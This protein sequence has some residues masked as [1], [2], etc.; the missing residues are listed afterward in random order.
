MRLIVALAA[1]KGWCIHLMD[2]QNNFLNRVIFEEVYMAIH[3]EFGRHGENIIKVCKL[4]KSLYGLNRLPHTVS[5][6]SQSSWFS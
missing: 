2:V 1:S 3:V 6:N 5:Q 4:H